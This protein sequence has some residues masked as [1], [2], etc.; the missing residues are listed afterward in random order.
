MVLPQTETHDWLP[1][2]SCIRSLVIRF[3]EG[4]S[5]GAKT[6]Y[7]EPGSPWENGSCESFNGKLRD[8]LLNGEIF[9]SLKE[10]KILIEQWRHP[11]W[12]E[13]QLCSSPNHAGTKY[14]SGQ[15]VTGQDAIAASSWRRLYR[16]QRSG[17]ARRCRGRVRCRMLPTG[18]SGRPAFGLSRQNSS[19]HKAGQADPGMQDFA[20]VRRQDLERDRAPALHSRRQRRP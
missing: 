18:R 2:G 13:H 10:A 8:E 4:T 9:Y 19:S 11:I 6:L 16:P 15:P 1:A 7:I 5:L 12:M 3:S 17:W 14:P 20:D